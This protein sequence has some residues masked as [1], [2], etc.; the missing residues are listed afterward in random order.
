MSDQHTAASVELDGSLRTLLEALRQEPA[1][2][3]AAALNTKL[4]KKF[5]KAHALSAEQLTARLE[6]LRAAGLAHG[7]APKTKTGPPR[8]WTQTVADCARRLDLTD[9]LRQPC[10]L[11]EFK[12][13][14]AAGMKGCATTEIK[15]ALDLLRAENRIH[16]WPKRGRASV[17]VALTPLSPQDYLNDLKS[18]LKALQTAVGKLVK[19]FQA[20]GVPPERVL[21]AARRMMA[22]ELAFT[23][24]PAEAASGGSVEE[25][26]KTT[27]FG[28]VIIERIV[29]LEP[30]AANG[31]P[32]SVRALRR[33]LAAELPD[34]QAFDRLLL[35]LA[36][37]Y[38][39]DLQRHDFPGALSEEERQSLVSDEYGNY[40]IGIS[41]R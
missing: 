30:A 20:A 4:R 12:K 17:R 37:E 35:Q 3:T 23:A 40:Y 14:L 13:K 2:L 18:P 22:E 27:D 8:Y 38:R 9:L 7:F 31:A 25:R 24:Q 36:D 33:A 21:D 15:E 11:T 6:E 5:G 1:P 34:K 39:V 28:H 10:T 41:L 16:T 29:Q 26:E 19:S 32:V